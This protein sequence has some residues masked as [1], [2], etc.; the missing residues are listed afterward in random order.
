MIR[1]TIASCVV[2][3]G[4]DENKDVICTVCSL[5]CRTSEEL[6]LQFQ[7]KFNRHF[8]FNEVMTIFSLKPRGYVNIFCYLYRALVLL[9]TTIFSEPYEDLKRYIEGR[10]VYFADSLNFNYSYQ[11]HNILYFVG[12]YLNLKETPF[13][14]YIQDIP[15]QRIQSENIYSSGNIFMFSILSYY[16]PTSLQK[17]VSS[18]VPLCNCSCILPKLYKTPEL[19]LHHLRVGCNVVVTS[20]YVITTCDCCTNIYCNSLECN[21]NNLDQFDLIPCNICHLHVCKDCIEKN[22]I[23]KSCRSTCLIE[24]YMRK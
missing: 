14:K 10:L 22:L 19:Y 3:N 12:F 8:D 5:S 9:S 23:C 24:N 6:M 16:L 7:R 2:C 21:T 11:Y 20:Q 15:E 17:I 4:S 13:Y 18:F 1:M